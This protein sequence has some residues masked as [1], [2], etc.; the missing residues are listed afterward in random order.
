M[1]SKEL[2]KYI[3]QVLH[4][5]I[6]VYPS[7]ELQKEALAIHNKTKYGFYDSLIIAAALESECTILYSEDLQNNQKINNLEIINPFTHP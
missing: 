5:L 6:E 3:D 7:I 1:T 2:S 4:P